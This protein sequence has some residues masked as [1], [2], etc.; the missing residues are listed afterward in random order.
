[1]SNDFVAKNIQYT[2]HEIVHYKIPLFAD[3]L[4]YYS[5]KL[6]KFPYSLQKSCI[7]HQLFLM[8]CY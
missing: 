6:I 7:S 1:M 4:Q 2:Y 3:N 5:S 8:I